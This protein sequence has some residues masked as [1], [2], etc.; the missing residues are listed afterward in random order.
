MKKLPERWRE[1]VMTR[2]NERGR[3]NRDMAKKWLELAFTI[4][5]DSERTV[6]RETVFTGVISMEAADDVGGDWG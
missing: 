2:E 5:L 3:A 6:L 1:G 4:P